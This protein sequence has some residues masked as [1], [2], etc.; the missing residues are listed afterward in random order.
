MHIIINYIN[1]MSILND[2]QGEK[3]DIQMMCKKLHDMLKKVEEIEIKIQENI[4]KFNKNLESLKK[5]INNYI[6]FLNQG[7]HEINNI[8]SKIDFTEDIRKNIEL[9]FDSVT[10]ISYSKNLN[11]IDSRKTIYKLFDEFIK[12]DFYP[13]CN[14]VIIHFNQNPSNDISQFSDIQN[15]SQNRMNLFNDINEI[16]EEQKTLTENDI[17]GYT[18]YKCSLS[19]N[20]ASYIYLNK[21]YCVNC[22]EKKKA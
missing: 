22:I 2:P 5:A 4:D 14:D 9:F 16:Q 13:N 11:I 7:N 18:N 3:K 1:K 20:K 10:N 21:K 17:N 12:Y 6:I 8:K 15:I 19:N